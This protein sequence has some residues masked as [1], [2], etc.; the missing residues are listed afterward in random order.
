MLAFGPSQAAVFLGMNTP[1]TPPTTPPKSVKPLTQ[2]VQPAQT[3]TKTG[4]RLPR[5]RYSRFMVQLL[6]SRL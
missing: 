4:N 6:H 3:E 1:T 5:Y 2:P